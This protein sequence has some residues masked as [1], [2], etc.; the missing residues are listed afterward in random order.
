MYRDT[1]QI[2]SFYAT[3]LGVT[4][5]RLLDPYVRPFWDGR[6]D[7]Y[8]AVFG[9][10]PPFLNM[11]DDAAKA[12]AIALM[13]ARHGAVIW[14]QT[15]AV[16]TILSK[17]HNL[18]LP[19]VHLD[20]LMLTHSL[21]FDDDPARLLDECWRVLDG[22]GKLLVMVPNRR[23]IWTHRETT[24]LG[25]G[26]PFSR[27]Q[28]ETALTQHGFEV[29]RV[30]RVVF[31]PPVQRGP[32]LRFASSCERFGQR[33]WPALGAILLI[34]ATKML[35]APAGNTRKVGTGKSSVLQVLSPSPY[36]DS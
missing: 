34:E 7:S 27:R 20:R 26:R 24:P 16:R 30:H 29:N 14:P 6:A 8:N 21:E 19:D 25:H 23:G 12:K 17:G 1:V 2:Q 9:Y 32:L 18:P 36:I 33:C 5:T 3:P 35:Y 4:V 11:I 13:P 22:A 15:G 10:G 31:I 28:L